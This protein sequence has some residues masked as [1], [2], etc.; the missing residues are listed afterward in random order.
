MAAV[1]KDWVRLR[2]LFCYILLLSII[3]R[4]GYKETKQEVG[5]IG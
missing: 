2:E 5:N 4:K 1:K 3:D